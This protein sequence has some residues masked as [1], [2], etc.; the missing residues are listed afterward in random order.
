MQQACLEARRSGSLV[1]PWSFVNKS[2][3]KGAGSKHMLMVGLVWWYSEVGVT[4]MVAA[5]LEGGLGFLFL[6]D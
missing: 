1:L 5:I 6:E 4:F 2:S 3:E